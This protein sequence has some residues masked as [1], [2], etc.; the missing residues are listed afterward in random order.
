MGIGKGGHVRIVILTALFVDSV[1]RILLIRHPMTK[2]L[3][4]AIGILLFLLFIG[5]TVFVP[6]FHR[7]HC[8]D[9]HATHEAANCP[10]CQFANTPVIGAVWHI[11]PITQALPEFRVSLPQLLSLCAIVSGPSQARAPPTCQ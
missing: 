10:I 6:A 5:G 1:L 11:G 9:N 2:G 3:T 4:K 7:A 8:A